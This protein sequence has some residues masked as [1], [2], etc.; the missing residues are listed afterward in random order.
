MITGET[1]VSR[2]EMLAIMTP[3]GV[4]YPPLQLR[5]GYDYQWTVERAGVAIAKFGSGG[6]DKAAALVGWCT[7]G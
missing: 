7:V 3:A 5:S 6:R 4:R 2:G 1:K